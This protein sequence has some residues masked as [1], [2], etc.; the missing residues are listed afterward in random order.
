MGVTLSGHHGAAVVLL[1]VMVHRQDHELA[2]IQHLNMAE[3][4]VMDS[5]KSKKLKIVES[6]GVEVKYFSIIIG[7]HGRAGSYLIL[8]N[9]YVF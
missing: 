5:S 3:A 8:A 1:V 4:I 7:K 2:L 6:K 9:F